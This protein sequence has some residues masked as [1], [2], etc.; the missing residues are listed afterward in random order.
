MYRFARVLNVVALVCLL[1]AGLGTSAAA[2]GIAAFPNASSLLSVSTLEQVLS[3]PPAPTVTT[4]TDARARADAE[5]PRALMP[6]YVSFAGLQVFDAHSTTR[7]IR[8][9]ASEANPLM[10]GLADKPAGML[11]VK[12]AGTAGVI[13]ASEQL[14]RR[15]K[16]AAVV[17]MLAAN[18]AL[19]W[20]V[21]HN[22]RAVR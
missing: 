16:T 3:P 19:A 8:H 17:F 5:R 4:A 10:R 21:Q 13:Y 9:G 18:S 14:W 11:A 15:N 7:A 22:Y 2:Q 12:A 6:L 20:V 1:D